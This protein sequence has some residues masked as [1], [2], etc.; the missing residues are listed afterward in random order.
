[1]DLRA[2]CAGLGRL[3]DRAASCRCGRPARVRFGSLTFDSVSDASTNSVPG[4]AA[5]SI[6]TN[7]GGVGAPS[8]AAAANTLTA[9]PRLGGGVVAAAFGEGEKAEKAVR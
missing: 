3:A 6:P 9:Q 4:V 8:P 2:G 7:L 5:W 1:M